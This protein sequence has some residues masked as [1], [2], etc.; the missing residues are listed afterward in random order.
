MVAIS[1]GVDSS[2]ATLLS[3]VL[4]QSLGRTR[5]GFGL[6]VIMWLLLGR[7]LSLMESQRFEKA[8]LGLWKPKME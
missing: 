3:V 6:G 8:V 7:N 4:G 5:P 2:I 1:G